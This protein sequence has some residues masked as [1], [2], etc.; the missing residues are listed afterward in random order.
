MKQTLLALTILA[1]FAL[2]GCGGEQKS[3][4]T[5]KLP[6]AKPA[7][8]IEEQQKQ[9]KS[10]ETKSSDQKEYKMGNKSKFGD[11]IG[12]ESSKPLHQFKTDKQ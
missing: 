12:K 2:T 7:V 3:A 9:T 6:E 1:A 10:F 8:K 5:S 4:P 11:Y